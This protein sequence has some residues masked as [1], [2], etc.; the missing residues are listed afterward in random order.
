MQIPDKH[1][2]TPLLVAV[3]EDHTD[4]V[5]LLLKKVPRVPYRILKLG[6]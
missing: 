3:F 2:I 6:E 5:E 1:G 4:C